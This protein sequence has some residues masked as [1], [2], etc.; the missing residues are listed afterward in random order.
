MSTDGENHPASFD[1]NAHAWL[2]MG[3]TKHLQQAA[4]TSPR[5]PTFG[6]EAAEIEL[7]NGPVAGIDEAGRGPW[8][9]PV[10]AAAVILRAADIPVGLDDSKALDAAERERL[11]D[12]I[13]VSG[14]SIGIGIAD[15]DRIDNM[16]ILRATLWAMAVAVSRL[17]IAPCTALI[18]GNQLPTL[19]CAT[20]TI[21]GGDATCVSIAAASIIAKVTR[22][23]IMIELAQ[24]HPGYGFE[25]HK[26]YGTPEHK[27]ALTR[28]GVS[29]HHRRSYRPVRLA[30]GIVTP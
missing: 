25:R 18:D 1:S 26:G 5:G 2:A 15:V 29:P 6:V 24:S 7:G 3:M 8:A 9:G 10:V 23:R 27:A 11:Y 4:V 22:D 14:A 21:V 30:L 17:D 28:L 19:T 16:N 20:R 12:A 13:V